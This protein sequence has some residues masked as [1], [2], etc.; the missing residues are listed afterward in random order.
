[1]RM[2][3]MMTLCTVDSREL[4]PLAGQY[5]IMRKR[6][7]PERERLTETVSEHRLFTNP[8]QSQGLPSS[9]LSTAVYGRNGDQSE[10]GHFNGKRDTS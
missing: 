2:M 5:H 8:Q 10:S 1:M 4:P 3:I 7:I 6:K 9:V